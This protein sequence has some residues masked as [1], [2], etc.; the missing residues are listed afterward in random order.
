MAGINTFIRLAN[1]AGALTYTGNGLSGSFIWGLQLE[2][3]ISASTYVPTTSTI[4]LNSTWYDVSGNNITGS[5]TNGVTFNNETQGS[6][7][8]DGTNDYVTCGNLN[9]GNTISVFSWF[10]STINNGSQ[11]VVVSKVDSGY[12]TGWEL[13]NNN[14]TLRATLRP[15][16]SNSNNVIGGTITLGNWYYGGFTCDNTTINLYLNGILTS[17]SAVSPAITLNSSE[18]VFV[19]R[20]TAGQYFTGKISN[21]QIYNR[22]LTQTEIQQNY[23][24]TKSRFG[25][26]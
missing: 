19:G 12:T 22:A 9:V 4:S 14:G 21:T 20:R 3:G 23:N 15:S 13:E 1:D 7:Y 10:N 8:F 6:L 25:L 26:I 2:K 18:N 17:T 5:L 24:A 11:N 16:V